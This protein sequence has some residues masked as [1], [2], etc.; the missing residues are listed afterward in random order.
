MRHLRG[1]EVFESERCDVRTGLLWW[2]LL[3]SAWS[4]VARASGRARAND[5]GNLFSRVKINYQGLFR[6]SSPFLSGGKGRASKE[7]RSEGII[8]LGLYVWELELR[9]CEGNAELG[10]G[11]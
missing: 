10:L 7:K 4:E 11:E 3:F 6:L 5:E 1:F 9:N 8:K 2:L